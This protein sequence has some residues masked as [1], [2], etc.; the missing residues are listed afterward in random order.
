MNSI[1]VAIEKIVEI[2]LRSRPIHTIILE[3]LVYLFIRLFTYGG[4]TKRTQ[5][6]SLL[7]VHGKSDVP[8]GENVHLGKLVRGAMPFSPF[9]QKM[10]KDNNLF[11]RA[12]YFCVRK[13]SVRQHVHLRLSLSR[14][15]Y[16]FQM[17]PFLYLWLPTTDVC[18]YDWRNL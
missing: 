3:K 4:G 18:D 16:Q 7:H 2:I 1:G 13:T 5:S 9:F 15:I 14:T 6:T 12:T 17:T 11:F 8:Y 10:N